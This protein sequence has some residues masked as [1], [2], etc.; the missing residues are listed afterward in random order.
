MTRIWSGNELQDQ[1]AAPV[2]FYRN[3]VGLIRDSTLILVAIMAAAITFRGGDAGKLSP[4]DWSVLIGLALCTVVGPLLIYG[5]YR[6]F[7]AMLREV[8]SWMIHLGPVGPRQPRG[9]VAA[10]RI[11]K[12][13][14]ERGTLRAAKREYAARERQA[15]AEFRAARPWVLKINRAILT[16]DAATDKFIPYLVALIYFAVFAYVL[17]YALGR[18]GTQ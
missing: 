2:A 5:I 8:S 14:I 16:L 18:F 3:L 7:F 6:V 11:W 1:W 9:P 4:A 13:R 15:K 17:W 12:L 10:Y